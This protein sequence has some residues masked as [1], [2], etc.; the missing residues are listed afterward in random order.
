M[1]LAAQDGFTPLF[2]AVESNHRTAVEVLCALCADVRQAHKV[3]CRRCSAV[4]CRRGQAHSSTRQQEG[5]TPMH[6]AAEQGLPDMVRLLHDL[7][8]SVDQ[9]DPVC[10]SRRVAQS[11]SV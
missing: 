11:R 7:G 3:S 10:S 9:A 5:F 8:A 6:V 1:A 4:A 2:L